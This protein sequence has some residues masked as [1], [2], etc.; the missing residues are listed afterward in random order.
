[1]RILS[2]LKPTG[3]P[4][5]GNYFG[6]MRQFVDLQSRGEGFYFIANLHALDQALGWLRQ[7]CGKTAYD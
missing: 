4:H 2:G 7:R 5:L 3:R 1:M 6:A